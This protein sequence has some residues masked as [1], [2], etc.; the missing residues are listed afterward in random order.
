MKKLTKTVTNRVVPAIKLARLGFFYSPTPKPQL[1]Y[2]FNRLYALKPKS[3][4]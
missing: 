4:V 1:F 3:P 2:A